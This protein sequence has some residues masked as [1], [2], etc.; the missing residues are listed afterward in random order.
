VNVII[1]KSDIR[2][3]KPPRDLSGKPETHAANGHAIP[4]NG[5]FIPENGFGCA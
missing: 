4:I 1:S 5:I 2:L 3:A